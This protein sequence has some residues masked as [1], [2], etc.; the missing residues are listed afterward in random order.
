MAPKNLGTGVSRT[1][2]LQDRA[3][4]QV[5]FNQ[6]RPALESEVNFLQEIEAG[7][8][9]ADRRSILP[10]GFLS[11]PEFAFIDD[12]DRPNT[13]LLPDSSGPPLTAHI[14]GWTIPVRGTEVEDLTGGTLNNPA[15][16]VILPAAPDIGS[17]FDLVYL[18]AWWAVVTGNS[19]V[20]PLKPPAKS[21]LDTSGQVVS[22]S[23]IWPFG[24]ILYGG[25]TLDDDIID[26]A[27]SLETSKRVQLQYA[28]RV[29]ENVDLTQWPRGLGQA[30]IVGFGPQE[31]FIGVPGTTFANA[32]DDTGDHGLWISE[33]PDLT[34]DGL[35][36][37]IPICAVHRRNL[38]GFNLD[39]N[40]NGSSPAADTAG[41]AL[42]PD[43]FASDR[44]VSVDIVDLRHKAVLSPEAASPSAR[45]LM[46]DVFA[47]VLNTS[48]GSDPSS[49]DV[50]G[51]RV[52]VP[53]LVV[54]QADFL[55]TR[56]EHVGAAD[57]ARR[58]FSDELSVEKDVFLS[59]V[60][61]DGNP[62]GPL[63]GDNIVTL[64]LPT[65][66]SVSFS[67]RE[68]RAVLSV[69]QED[70]TFTS[71][72]VAAGGKSI[73]LTFGVG[74]SDGADIGQ[75][76]W[77]YFDLEVPNTSGLRAEPDEMQDIIATAL[78]LTSI[79][80]EGKRVTASEQNNSFYGRI[81]VG[82]GNRMVTA[83]RRL[84]APLSD[85]RLTEGANTFF[86]GMLDLDAYLNGAEPIRVPDSAITVDLLSGRID[87]L[88]DLDN[89]IF[90]LDAGWISGRNAMFVRP[91]NIS[92]TTS[93]TLSKLLM[94]TNALYVIRDN[95]LPSGVALFT[96]LAPTPLLHL[97]GAYVND[98]HTTSDLTTGPADEL[99][100]NLVS[101]EQ[102]VAGSVVN[103]GQGVNTYRLAEPPVM[104]ILK[105]T[106]TTVSGT[107]TVYDV[108]SLREDV[109]G[110]L[111]VPIYI[112]ES[113]VT[114]Q[115]ALLKR[116]RTVAG[117]E[118]E[119][120]EFNT[121]DPDSLNFVENFRVTYRKSSDVTSVPA[122]TDFMIESS[123]F[124]SDKQAAA[125]DTIS[126]GRD[127][128]IAAGVINGTEVF[129]DADIRVAL[130][131][132][133]TLT[134][135]IS[136]VPRQVASMETDIFHIVDVPSEMIVTS[137]SAGQLGDAVVPGFAARATENVFVSGAAISGG[138]ESGPISLL[139]SQT[140]NAFISIPVVGSAGRDPVSALSG[141]QIRLS[142][143]GADWFGTL[144][145]ENG[146]TIRAVAEG[147]AIS[148]DGD[149]AAYL[150]VT[151][152][153]KTGEIV[154]LIL[155]QRNMGSGQPVID[156]TAG[157]FAVSVFRIENRPLVIS[158]SK[159]A[160]SA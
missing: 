115:M 99:V 91:M 150:P 124:V 37:A 31:P 101:D 120:F 92:E 7:L 96:L 17:R 65:E 46:R 77:L 61:T 140:G 38:A 73:A 59:I 134:A 30:D 66:S 83:D 123:D 58:I 135:P 159:T 122:D 11:F 4:Q 117:T 21:R 81:Y 10:S 143:P 106:R 53:K 57:G 128:F 39:G 49:S 132:D 56:N 158:G 157:N 78:P 41:L 95:V 114:D 12:E 29:W 27:V 107:T 20:E 32:G 22:K 118:F 103:R 156:T 133:S 9:A 25:D 82:R 113:S 154:V 8:R 111:I 19:N 109:F 76:I 64:I 131:L 18:E 104:Q 23:Q 121:D 45:R 71:V 24:N 36:Y 80:V 72:S 94:S 87:G 14:N 13:F 151:A 40:P 105:I 153:A 5:V 125:P 75:A 89:D 116:T 62:W 60:R 28:I 147:V 67:L 69:T 50:T 63:A 90:N 85:A 102:L 3:W 142:A 33:L 70:I 88:I 145:D 6:G 26:P 155:S 74:S 129:L 126:P 48:A 110:E 152:R 130:P 148:T 79:S 144:L 51:S 2:D 34:A 55:T 149:V 108:G 97:R 43:G 68:P 1:L 93:G 98:T 35:V 84:P 138:F 139:G 54:T 52:S 127:A 146:D 137:A 42:R 16:R 100:G 44:V 141:R 112:R 160:H 86:E 136:H 47:G 119:A 15:N